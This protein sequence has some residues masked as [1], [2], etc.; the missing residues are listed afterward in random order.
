MT[1]NFLKF[2]GS[3]TN[4]KKWD[5][6]NA[7]WEA[8]GSFVSLFSQYGASSLWQNHD[9]SG[10]C[11]LFLINPLSQTLA[12]HHHF[13]RTS[14][15]RCSKKY[16]L[17]N[18]T[19]PYYFSFGNYSIKIQLKEMIPYLQELQKNFPI[20][21]FPEIQMDKIFPFKN[22]NIW[23]MLWPQFIFSLL[24]SSGFALVI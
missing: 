5:I 15:D 16:S 8:D 19:L 4:A 14:H 17:N 10:V 3:K 1:F 6:H 13:F 12:V 7:A 24:F 11:F 20:F 23:R 2:L 21:K 18:Q 9:S 22:L